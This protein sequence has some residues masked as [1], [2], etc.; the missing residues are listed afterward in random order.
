MGQPL[1]VGPVALGDLAL[2]AVLIA[3]Q[4]ERAGVAAFYQGDEVFVF[5]Q[6][7]G[8]FRAGNWG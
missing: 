3:V 5:D 7:V 1:G 4:G 8:H 6:A 2:G